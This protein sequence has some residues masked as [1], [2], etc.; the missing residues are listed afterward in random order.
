[1]EKKM[2]ALQKDTANR[3]LGKKPQVCKVCGASGEFETYTVREMMQGTKEEFLYFACGSCNC[4]QIEKIPENLTDYYRDGYYSFRMEESPDMTFETSVKKMTKVLD[5]GCGSG[6]WLVEKA[7]EGWGNLY[8]CDPFLENGR[9]YGDRVQIYNCS[10]H[11]MEGDKTFDIIHMQDSFEHMPDP[12]AVLKSVRRLLKEDGILYMSIPVYPNIA[13]DRFQTHWY[14]LD[15]PRHLFLHSKESLAWLATESGMRIYN[16]RYDSNGSQFVRSFLYEHGIP[17]DEQDFVRYFS[18]QDLAAL[19]QEAVAW[20]E[21]EY[22]DHMEVYWKK[23]GT[24]AAGDGKKL[25]FQRFPGSGRSFPYPPLYVEPDADY[26]CFTDNKAVHS[27]TWQ[28]QMVESLEDKALEPYL[29][30]YAY[31]WELY[32]EQIQMGPLFCGEGEENIAAVPAADNLPLVPLDLG[33]FVPTADEKGQYL[34]RKNPVYKKGKYNGRPLLLTIGVPVSNQIDTIDRCLSHIKPLLDGLDAEL[35]AID[36][37]STDGTIEVCRSYGARVIEHPWHDNM[38]AV[39]NEGIY[40][41]KGQWYL[42]IDDDE[43]FEDV[44]EILQFFK[45]GTYRD[46]N[47]ASYLQRNY[48]DCMGQ[49]YEDYQAVR[50]AEITPDLHFEGRIHDALVIDGNIKSCALCDYAHHY[51][52]VEDRPEWKKEKFLRNTPILLYDVYEYPD[53]LRYLLQLA[54]EYS[55]IWRNDIALPLFASLMARAKESRKSYGETTGLAKLI[56][57]LYAMD[58]PR[59]FSWPDFLQEGYDLADAQR[60]GIAWMQTTRAFQMKK[61]AGQ[62]LS[63][64]DTYRKY[65]EKYRKEPGASRWR[66]F[67]GL[68]KVEHVRYVAEADAAAFC[69]YVKSARNE[70]ALALLPELA[71]DI[72]KNRRE[73][74][75]LAGLSAGDE[76]FGA[77][78]ERLT[79]M[80]WEE[81]SGQ[82]LTIWAE[83][84]RNDILCSRQL[85]RIPDLFARI[86][87]PAVYGW[88]REENSRSGKTGERLLAY[89]FAADLSNAPVQVLALC[90]QLLKEEYIRR[91]AEGSMELLRR[92]VLVSGLFAEYYYHPARLSDV[93]DCSIPPDA[94][95]L[96]RMAVVLA[97]GVPSS[98]NTALLREALAIFPGF[99][100]EIRMIIQELKRADR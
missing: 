38:S 32:P 48:T 91:R 51:G 54:N 35:I 17:Y 87:V 15:A 71:L 6:A 69:A 75:I 29:A 61:P 41:A 49:L 23:A 19:E 67:S 95:A 26:I 79:P 36:T 85:A 72:A 13:F 33:K 84:V 30:Q 21:K 74:A 82:I 37:G 73:E 65:L 4:L 97:D 5:V 2:R 20:N 31:R 28:V 9:R 46:Y 77:F 11:E 80:Q 78:C 68:A 63:Y 42:S 70:E 27:N 45:K 56:D 52:F 18:R 58:D 86:S 94:R 88:V 14:Q 62:V 98:E 39:R 64:Y 43:W 66:M 55:A 34:Y 83:S 24:L 90:E 40:H 96:Y 47:M 12:L 57:C 22:G 60:A 59:L 10:I 3:S 44:G 76:V 81:W 25:I 89:A 50:M 99:H 16:T 7:M 93:R 53:D 92:Y 100:E 8:G 1:M